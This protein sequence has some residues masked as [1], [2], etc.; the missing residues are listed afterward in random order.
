MRREFIVKPIDGSFSLKEHI[1]DV[2][3]EGIMAMDIY[4]LDA[5]LK[6]DERQLSDQLNISRTPI[7]ERSRVWSRRAWC[8]SSR[9]AACS[10]SGNRS[11]RSWR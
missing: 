2:L 1:Y 10:S 6:L 9:A 11:T 3:K 4:A 8:A 5:R 7:R